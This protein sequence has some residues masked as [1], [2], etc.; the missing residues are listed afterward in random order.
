MVTY[1]INTPI[2]NSGG[3][4]GLPEHVGKLNLSNGIEYLLN[5]QG[6][7]LPD[8]AFARLTN[9]VSAELDDGVTEI[10]T[11]AFQ[12]CTSLSAITLS[13]SLTSIGNYAFNNCVKLS[14]ITIP[15]S[16]TS[17]GQSSFYYTPI[18]SI[19]IPDGITTIEYDTFTMCTNLSSVTLPTSVTTLNGCFRRTK[20]T[21]DSVPSHVTKIQGSCFGECYYIPSFT[22]HDGITELGTF[23]GCSA[24]KFF[25]FPSGF[26]TILPNMF[27]N[28]TALSSVTIPSCEEIGANAFY[29][30]PN[31]KTFDFTNVKTIGNQAFYRSGISNFHFGEKLE[32]IGSRAIYDSYTVS[33]ITFEGK[34]APSAPSNP[35]YSVKNK[36]TLYLPNAV[37]SDY[38]TIIGYLPTGWTV[39][40]ATTLTP[41]DSKYVKYFSNGQ[42]VYID[43]FPT[44]E[45][46]NVLITNFDALEIGTG[47][48]S[49]GQ[50]AFQNKSFATVTIPNSVTNIG[51]AAF[52][53]NTNL[54][55]VTIGSNVNLID[56]GAFYGCTSLSSITSNAT[57]APSLGQS[58]FE[59]IAESGTLSYPSGSESSYSSWYYSLPSGW[60]PNLTPPNPGPSDGGGNEDDAD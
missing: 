16:V 27:Q 8:G 33:A 32:S 29:M 13:D 3:G 40:D 28:C 17:I 7:K 43:F 18:E 50:Q 19:V 53:G 42:C 20:L 36:G 46:S 44:G 2:I 58:V 39:Q 15:S 11:A 31:L 26:K 12:G 45:I 41:T 25:V 52:L 1:L 9:A 23:G 37:R 22:C 4:G 34:T 14:G 6:S 54:T 55:S 35:F 21:W 51:M 38:S 47:I 56:S 49:I 10:G 60:N 59:S 57:V 30:N 24:M 48:T 5:F